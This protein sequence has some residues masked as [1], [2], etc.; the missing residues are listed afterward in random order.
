MSISS[1]PLLGGTKF[2]S[3]IEL[4]RDAVEEGRK[5]YQRERR[6]SEKRGEAASLAPAQRWMRHWFEPLTLDIRRLQ[7]ALKRGEDAGQGY[8]KFAPAILAVNAKKL[9]TIAMSQLLGCCIVEPNGVKLVHAARTVGRAVIAEAQTQ[10]WKNEKN[11]EL[12]KMLYRV[13][14]RYKLTSKKVQWFA[15][16][17]DPETFFDDDTLAHVGSKLI[18]YVVNNA[19]AA[20]YE[21]GEFRF[22]FRHTVNRT[23]ATQQKVVKLDDDVL[24]AISHDHKM[25]ETL[26]PIYPPMTV[27]PFQWKDNRGGYIELRKSIIKKSTREQRD[28]LKANEANMDSFYECHATLGQTAMRVDREG[29]EVVQALFDEGGG[30]LNIPRRDDWEIGPRFPETATEEEIKARKK[31]AAILHQ[32]NVYLFSERCLFQATVGMATKTKHWPALYFPHDCDFR[33]RSYPIPMYL[34]HHGDDLPRGMLEFSE[35]VPCDKEGM[36]NV[37]IHAANMWKHGGLDKLPF[38]DRIQ[39]TYDNL[40][41]IVTSAHDPLQNRWWMGAKKPLQFLAACRALRDPAKAA[42]LMFGIDGTFNGMQHYAALS[43]DTDCARLANLIDSDTPAVP[44]KL[45]GERVKALLVADGTEMALRI[46]PHVDGDLVKTNAMTT[47]YG[48]TEIGAREQVGDAIAEMGFEGKEWFEATKLLSK[49]TL[50]AIGD[51]FAG[52]VAYMD[53]ISDVARMIADRGHPVTWNTTLGFPVVQSYRKDKAMK[54]N[55]AYGSI[56]VAT[57]NSSLPVRPA[58]QASA[59]PPNFIHSVDA[60]HLLMTARACSRAGIAFAGVHDGYKTHAQHGRRLAE[61]TKQQFV[62]LHD[63]PG[64][65]G[66]AVDRWRSLYPDLAIPEPPTRGDFDLQQVLSSRYFFS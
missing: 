66:L 16:L 63:G 62:A 4:E 56:T 36:N 38:A 47:V 14:K 64:P 22:A 54:I 8:T 9:A 53:Y 49:T 2:G 28:A 57:D 11:D 45:V 7:K 33:D 15:K 52:A 26:R 25:M 20:G 48:V 13:Q 24:R 50:A 31:E 10:I 61:L 43:R 5:R 29:M 18:W 34:N 59:C 6:K 19:S 32:K 12:L 40:N 27:P 37:A 21:S 58:K 3:Q 42:H 55:T 44:Y 51:L 30:V 65:L 41:S 1:S 23:G 39:W 17:N 35:A 46:A 60:T